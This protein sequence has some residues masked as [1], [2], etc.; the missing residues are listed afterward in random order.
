MRIANCV[1][2]AFAAVIGVLIAFRIIFEQSFQALPF[3][4]AG[5]VGIVVMLVTGAG[6]TINDYFDVAIDTI[7]R[8]DRPIPSGR[9]SKKQA[10]FF[11]AFLFIVGITIAWFINLVC[12]LIALLNSFLLVLYA[13][14]LKTTP[15]FGNAAVGYLTGSTFLF[16]AAVFGIEGLY[17]LSVLFLLATLAT[18]AREI[19][20]DIEDME[21]DLK[22]GA[23]TLPILIGKKQ[24]GLVASVLA[25]IGIAASPYPYLNSMLGEYYLPLVGIA[26]LLFIAAV[27]SVLKNDPVL[28][29]KRFKLAMFMAL[30]AFVAGA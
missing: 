9:V 24:A 26:D 19:V 20:K 4:E 18:I 2:A 30:F 14:N 8:P 7:N 5:G 3:F 28:S 27:Y 21:G 6:N 23:T 17:A 15:F 13:R 12:A 22:A 16:G 10:L 1:M 25:L 29:S 11:A